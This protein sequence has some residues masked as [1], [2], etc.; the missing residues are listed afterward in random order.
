MIQRVQT[1]WMALTVALVC[2]AALMPAVTFSMGGAEFRLM[3]YGMVA[4]GSG[5]A[6]LVLAGEEAAGGVVTSMLSVCVAVMLALAALVPFVAIFLFKRRQLQARLLGA[7][8]ALLLGAAGLMAWYIVSTLRNVVATSSDNYFLSFFPALLV[9]ALVTNWA[10]L[11]GVL[12]D[13][14]IV[15]AADRIR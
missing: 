3:S 6:V 11:R 5:G 4:G 12:R 13:E 2:V 7:E 9:V 15:R 1:L 10:A 14:M 8:F